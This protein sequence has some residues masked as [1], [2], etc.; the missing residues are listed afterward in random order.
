[1][2]VMITDTEADVKREEQQIADFSKTRQAAELLSTRAETGM[3]I[4][5]R[6]VFWGTLSYCFSHFDKLLLV[7]FC[8]LSG[9]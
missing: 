3:L 2:A 4:M 5:P 6:S 8:L 7:G 1:M 9:H